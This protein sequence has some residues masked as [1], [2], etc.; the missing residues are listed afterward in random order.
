MKRTAV[1]WSMAI[2][3]AACGGGKKQDNTT[4]VGGGEGEEIAKPEGGNDGAM[5]AP[6]TMDEIQRMF[7]RRRPAVSRCL[8]T[9]VDSQE[10]PKNARGKM[11]L[12]VTIMP[13]GKPGEIKV[14][15]ASLESKALEDCV[16]ARLRETQFPDVPEP[17][18]TTYTY[19]FE[20]M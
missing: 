9:A 12:S 6:E 20:A 4:P 17:Y 2:A 18:P 14:I 19:G 15:K 1:S 10:L 3:L 5:V 7:D 16:I 8:S 11:T 13:G